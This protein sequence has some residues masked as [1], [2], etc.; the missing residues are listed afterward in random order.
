MEVI[1]ITLIF[2]LTVTK[3]LS[4]IVTN[5]TALGIAEGLKERTQ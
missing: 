1:K 2:S 3:S 4:H 5:K